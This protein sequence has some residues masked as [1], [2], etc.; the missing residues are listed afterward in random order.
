MTGTNYEVHH[1][2][3]LLT[4]HFSSHLDLNIRLRILFSNMLSV[5]SS[6]NVIDH[7]SQSFSTT[8]DIIAL[9]IL[10]LNSLRGIE[11]TT[12]C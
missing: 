7:V 2:E 8:G 5:L 12:V 9:N 1:C 4:P 10:I 6:L 11:K 3:N